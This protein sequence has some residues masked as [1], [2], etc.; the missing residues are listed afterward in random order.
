MF[1]FVRVCETVCD[2]VPL[3]A[4]KVNKYDVP[5]HVQLVGFVLCVL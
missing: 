1:I 5:I 2:C 4:L 3:I